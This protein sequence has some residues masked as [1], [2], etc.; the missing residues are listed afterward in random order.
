M[1]LRTCCRKLIYPGNSVANPH[2]SQKEIYKNKNIQKQLGWDDQLPASASGEPRIRWEDLGTRMEYIGYPR[3][4]IN[5]YIYIYM[6]IYIYTVCIYLYNIYTSNLSLYVFVYSDLCWICNPESMICKFV[7]TFG[8]SDDKPLELARTVRALTT[9][10]NLEH[11]Q[12][13]VN[14]PTLV[15]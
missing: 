3:H 4:W 13:L 11:V 6:Y 14:P 8:M 5:I 2:E 7:P 12:T 1:D 9:K 10:C 15:D